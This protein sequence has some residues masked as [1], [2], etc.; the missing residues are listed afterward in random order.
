MKHYYRYQFQA[1]LRTVMWRLPSE[2]RDRFFFLGNDWTRGAESLA[3][4]DPARRPKFLICL[5][6]T[7]L[8][9]QAMHQH[10]SRWHRQFEELTLYPKF[11]VGFGHSAHLHPDHVFR[12]PIERSLVDKEEVLALLSDGMSVFVEEC[13]TF[14]PAHLPEIDTEEFFRCLVA[15]P[16]V[17]RSVAFP[18]LTRALNE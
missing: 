6:F 12:I 2:P 7:V 11:L 10:F 8:V 17:Q 18:H 4:L 3:R 1:D 13:R 16:D 14:F 15:D 5:F 9:D